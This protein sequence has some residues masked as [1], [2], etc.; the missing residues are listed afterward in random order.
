MT[1]IVSVSGGLASAA[2]AILAARS[3]E[4]YVMFFADTTEEDA[5]LHRFLVDIERYLGQQIIRLK[6]G[7]DT[8]DVFVDEEYIGNSRVAPCSR[9]LKTVPVQRMASLFP[10]S[11]P[12]ILGMS[13]DE[14]ERIVRAQKNWGDRPVR[15]LIAEQ[16]LSGAAVKALVCDDAGIKQPRIYDMGFPHNNCSGKCPRAG[17]GQFARLLDMTP[18]VYAHHEQRNEWARAE[19]MKRAILKIAAGTYRGKSGVGSSGGF[20]RVQ[21]NGKTEYLHMKEFRER[22]QSGELIPARYEMGGCGCFVDDEL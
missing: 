2:N 13:Y 1:L 22:V 10:I 15:S 14:E 18:D 4:S 7:R 5:D 20:I 8:W 16:R 17:Q 9:I 19:I 6:D 12:L 21:R 11:D 3:G